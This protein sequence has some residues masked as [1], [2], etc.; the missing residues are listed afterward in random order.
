MGRETEL[1]RAAAGQ[2]GD[3]DLETL[4][5]VAA[6]AWPDGQAPMQTL[7]FESG[8]LS[9]A[10]AGWT[11]QQIALFRSQLGSAGWSVTAEGGVL[12]IAR[13]RTAS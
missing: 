1:L 5:G 6:S 11:E 2:S 13:A 4:L 12:T 9:F 8:R 3:G 10:T 7:R